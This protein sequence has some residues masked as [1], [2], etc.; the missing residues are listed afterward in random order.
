[1]KCRSA[2][3][4][5]CVVPGEASSGSG[6]KKLSEEISCRLRHLGWSRHGALLLFVVPS[7]S[8]TSLRKALS[9][10]RNCLLQTFICILCVTASASCKLEFFTFIMGSC[11]GIASWVTRGPG[12]ELIYSLYVTDVL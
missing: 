12:A 7:R 9:G 6:R 10:S 8:G 5:E 11:L 2:S 4:P 1:V 3:G